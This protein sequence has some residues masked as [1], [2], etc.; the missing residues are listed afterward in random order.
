MKYTVV[1]ALQVPT[2]TM[3]SVS[4]EQAIARGPTQLRHVK[5]NV[6]EA[7][8]PVWFK[9]GEFVGI[10]DPAKHLLPDLE[11]GGKTAD[12]EKPREKDEPKPPM[13]TPDIPTA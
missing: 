9:A 10:D 8:Q 7:L 3:V 12:S 11:P 1:K 2:G 13:K 5:G 6:H 4:K